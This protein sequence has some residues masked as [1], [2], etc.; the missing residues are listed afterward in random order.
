MGAEKKKKEQGVRGGRAKKE[1]EKRSNNFH[2]NKSK[3][4]LNNNHNVLFHVL[5]LQIRSTYP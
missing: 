1:K 5:F 4:H 2:G 3:Y